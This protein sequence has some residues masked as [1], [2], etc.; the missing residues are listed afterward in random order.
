MTIKEFA[1]KYNLEKRTVDYFTTIGIFHPKEAK[2]ENT[3]YKVYRDYDER[4]ER[5]A[6]IVVICLAAGMKLEDISTWTKVILN[7]GDSKIPSMM[8]KF[9]TELIEVERAKATKLYDDALMYIEE[10]I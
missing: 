7:D 5:E 6:K 9:F 4:C 3:T 2:S 1:K 8:R 10:G